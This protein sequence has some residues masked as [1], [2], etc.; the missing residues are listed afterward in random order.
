MSLAIVLRIFT[1]VHN[2]SKRALTPFLTHVRSQVTATQPRTDYS[3]R[4]NDELSVAPGLRAEAVVGNDQR[5]ARG[6][7]LADPLDRLRRHFDA[8]ERLRGSRGRFQLRWGR[9]RR[10]LLLVASAHGCAGRFGR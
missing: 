5:G 7:D 9:R 4:D 6:Q 8:V 1:R 3:A 10:V 2:P